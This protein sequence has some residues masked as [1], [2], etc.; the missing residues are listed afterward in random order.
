MSD[1]HDTQDTHITGYRF[2]ILIWVDLLILTLLTIEIAQF[3]FQALTVIVALVIASIKSFLVAKHFMHLK[4]ENR[5]L[6]T[7]VLG[8]GILF[9][10]VLIVLF[11]D[12]L[13]I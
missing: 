13:F 2:G 6:N 10:A 1:T 12:Y 7:V 8:V 4:F 5:F 11:S 9:L 3:D